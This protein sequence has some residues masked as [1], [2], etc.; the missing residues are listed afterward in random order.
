VQRWRLFLVEPLLGYIS[1]IQALNY[2]INLINNFI[3]NI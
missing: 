1:K 2:D 3:K